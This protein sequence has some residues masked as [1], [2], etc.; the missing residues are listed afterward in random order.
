MAKVRE[1]VE[2]LALAHWPR[3]YGGLAVAFVVGAGTLSA[4][5][6]LPLDEMT[7]AKWGLVAAAVVVVLA[8]WGLTARYPRANRGRVGVLVAIR[9][10]DDDHYRRL[11]LDFILQ[12][13]EQLHIGLEEHR[14]QLV[15]F[16]PA[17][18]EGLAD[19]KTIERA[20]KTARCAF[21]LFGQVRQR[22]VRG[23]DVHFVDLRGKVLLHGPLPPTV[24]DNLA[25]EFSSVMPPR[26]FRVGKDDEVLAFQF[27]AEWID[28]AARY[29]LGLAALASN[30]LD[31]AERLLLDVRERVCKRQ[32]RNAG[33]KSIAAR[34]N[35]PLVALYDARARRALARYHD[36][37]SA[38][39][40]R[41]VQAYAER[42]LA[43]DSSSYS[44][45]LA[46]AFCAFELTRDVQAAR[47]WVRMCASEPD[48]AWRYSEGFLFC[49][50]GKIASARKSY[51]KAFARRRSNIDVARQC[52]EHI[53]SVLAREPER[54]HLHFAVALIAF[55]V[56]KDMPSVVSHG[57]TFLAT[58]PA[59]KSLADRRYL[60]GLVG[61]AEHET[62]VD[63]ASPAAMPTPRGAVNP[64]PRANPAATPAGTSAPDVGRGGR[65]QAAPRAA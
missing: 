14:L 29:V 4:V 44:A 1:F 3:W 57:R 64:A 19:S 24:A 15:E 53:A 25:W 2:E 49:Y 42:M 41:E 17:Q 10:E 59:D 56:L 47:T 36:S 16:S 35:R 23:E 39:D 46:L 30:D 52:V 22:K 43:Y 38:S 28:G 45:R 50:E 61:K 63:P 32:V 12:L 7:T 51:S 65:V 62:G 8:L 5:A 26:Q 21:V 54:Y 6:A 13:R 37:Q 55:N 9:C 34:V 27:T 40:L 58:S 31:Y 18:A 11:R 20:A 33:I 60:E 48:V